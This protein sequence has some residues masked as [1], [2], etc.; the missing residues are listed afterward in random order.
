MEYYDQIQ[1][2]ATYIRSQ[3]PSAPEIGIISGT[4]ISLPGLEL[5]A[6]QKIRYQDIP[7][8]TTPTVSSHSGELTIGN[9]ADREVAWFKGRYHFY[10]GLSMKQ[11]AFPARVFAALGGKMLVLINAA[12]GVN[13]NFQVGDLALITDHINFMQDNPLIGEND[14]RLGPRFPDMSQVYDLSAIEVGQQAAQEMS[15][16]L[17]QGVYLALPGPS[18]E[19]RAEYEMVRRLGADLVGMS[20]VP[21]VIAARHNGLQ[22]LGISIVTNVVQ[23]KEPLTKTTID[24]VIEVADRASEKL[25][26]LLN[27]MLSKL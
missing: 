23:P 20:T 10:E 9:V 12:G 27:K 3:T 7:G 1:E 19:T 4:G 24:E 14:D 21:E 18:L 11:V 26:P 6:D 22:V 13:P 5:A 16:D 25:G 15:I 8:F 17:K 2:A